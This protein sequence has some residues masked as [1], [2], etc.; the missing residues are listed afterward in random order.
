MIPGFIYK[1]FMKK[2]DDLRPYK[3]IVLTHEP[4][5]DDGKVIFIFSSMHTS[6]KI[7]CVVTD[8][9]ANEIQSH[10]F[11]LLTLK[12]VIVDKQGDIYGDY[13]SFEGEQ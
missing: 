7:K 5:D 10:L 4:I 13:V 8:E 9:V 6:D 11:G 2:P 12:N 1:K 3:V